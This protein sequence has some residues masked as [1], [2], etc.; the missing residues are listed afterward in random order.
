MVV[1][2]SSFWM[3]PTLTPAIFTSSPGMTEK[4]LSKMAR[5]RYVLLPPAPVA[6]TAMIAAQAPTS[7]AEI[8]RLMGRAR[9]L[10][11]LLSGED[12]DANLAERYGCFN[13]A[14]P[15]AA[16]DGFVKALAHRIAGFPAAGQLAV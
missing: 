11:V 10:E 15:A 4:A 12:Y 1:Q 2:I 7:S 6:S 14:L 8:A 5:T 16:L 13:R 9:A 3:L